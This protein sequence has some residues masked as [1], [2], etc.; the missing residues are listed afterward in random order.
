MDKI[1]WYKNS[2]NTPKKNQNRNMFSLIRTKISPLKDRNYTIDRSSN[3]Y[4][5]S[6]KELFTEQHSQFVRT[7]R[8]FT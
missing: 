1:M 2:Q 5:G 7:C 8:I 4:F 6:F 3:F